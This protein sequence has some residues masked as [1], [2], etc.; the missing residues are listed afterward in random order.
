MLGLGLRSRLKRAIGGEPPA[1]PPAS[2]PQ[3]EVYPQV[4]AF[5]WRPRMGD[6]INF[7]DHLAHVVVDRMLAERGFNREEEVARATRL[8][9][10]GS[11]LHFA[12]S[13]DTIW[14]SGINGKMG[15]E[16]H[17]FST[18]DVRAVRGPRTAEYL[19]KRGITVPDVFGDPALLLPDLF[20][21][22]FR[23]TGGGGPIFVPNL[24]DLGEVETDLSLISPLRGWNHVV[25]RI[26]RSD[27]VLASSLHGL[28]IAEAFGIPAR[29]VRLS[30][31]EALFKFEDYV[32]GTGRS[33]L[34]YATSIPQGLEMGGMAPID[35][36]PAPLKAAF[37]FDLWEQPA[38]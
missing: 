14:G 23:R 24:N 9:S 2:P 5:A 11:V 17:Q 3:H 18:L 32:F 26:L 20:G 15:D 30:E 4:E 36:D 35:W 7:G 38:A 28:I 33:G 31:R 10:I 27:L 6:H 37:P 8:F 12:S 29:Y 21:S 19:R 16:L 34:D 22:R 1:P 25:E 13:G